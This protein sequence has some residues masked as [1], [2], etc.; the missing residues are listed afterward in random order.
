MMQ[1]QNQRLDIW[2]VLLTQ[3]LTHRA[4]SGPDINFRIVGAEGAKEIDPS[5]GVTLQRESQEG[6]SV[7]AR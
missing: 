1:I 6:Y 2:L 3:F 4:K 7:F 5:R